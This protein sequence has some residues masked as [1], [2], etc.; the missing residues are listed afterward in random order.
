MRAQLLPNRKALIWGLFL[1]LL[2]YLFLGFGFPFWISTSLFITIYSLLLFINNLSENLA[3][4]ELA[5]F[6]TCFQL[7]FGSL[8]AFYVVEPDPIF[9]PEGTPQEYFA[10]AIPAVIAFGLGLFMIKPSVND[11]YLLSKAKEKYDLERIGKLLVVIGLVAEP[12][13]LLMPGSLRY[14][15]DL[16]SI[17]KFIGAF[18]LIFDDLKKSRIYIGLAFL[19][20]F[21]NAISGGVFFL[22]LIWG[23]FA[24]MFFFL[25]HSEYSFLKKATYIVV[26]ISFVFVLDSAKGAYRKNLNDLG[27]D[28]STIDKVM[29][30]FDLYSQ[31][32]VSD[33]LDNEE[34]VSGRVTRINQGAIV[35][36]IMQYVP[37]MEDHAGGSTIKDAIIGAIFPR[38]LLPDKVQAGGVENYEKYTGRYLIA[39]SINISL[40]GEGYINYGTTGGILFMFFVGLFYSLSYKLLSKYA[41]KY[42][43]YIFFVPYFFIYS[44]KAEDDLATP[45]NHIF[46]AFIVFIFLNQVYLK[47]FFQKSIKDN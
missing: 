29:I 41:S 16:I 12:I 33:D 20:L 40:L 10:Y 36:W 15:V 17:L 38:I 31:S 18:I 22:L 13:K 19:P 30:F 24:V 5:F 37:E 26:G 25:S 34:N 47:K 8:L 32:L 14:F 23:V 9:E 3:F 43:V 1:Y 45:L 44:I 46:K 28:V 11:L 27:G 6:T 4:R 2:S 7:L 35:T 39:T 42:P 21:I